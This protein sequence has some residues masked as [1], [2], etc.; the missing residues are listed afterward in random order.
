MDISVVPATR[1]ARHLGITLEAGCRLLPTWIWK[2]APADPCCSMSGGWLNQKATQVLVQTLVISR[3]VYCNY[4]V[5][6]LV[7]STSLVFNPPGSSTLHPP[8]HPELTT[9]GCSNPMPKSLVLAYPAYI[10]H[11]VKPWTPAGPLRS[12]T[13][14]RLATL[15]LSLSKIAIFCRPGAITVDLAHHWHED[16]WNPSY[17]PPQAENSSVKTAS[18]PLNKIYMLTKYIYIYIYILYLLFL[19]C[20]TQSS[21][22]ALPI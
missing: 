6:G 18:W 7:C 19:Y 5:V 10:Q 11:M 21:C 2:P 12:K 9:G 13:A 14:K 16:S 8:P 4:L 20:S 1:T 3:P 17:L 22:F 15:S